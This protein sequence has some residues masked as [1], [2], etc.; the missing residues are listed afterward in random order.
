MAETKE[1]I[2]K[3]IRRFLKENT[4]AVIATISPKNEPNAATIN[5]IIEEVEEDFS[6]YFIARKSSRKFENIMH[7]RNVGLVVGTD[8]KV[9]A[10]AEIQGI[11]HLIENPKPKIAEYF[12]KAMASGK[13]E[14]WPLVKAA[15]SMDYGFFRVEV[16]W[17]RWLDLVTSSDFHTFRGSFYEM[18]D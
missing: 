13:Q 15:K 3:R 4:T 6:L 10:M 18:T 7:N 16:E 8:P 17:L 2:Q 1:E 9:P 14:F 5:Y 12:S 11:A